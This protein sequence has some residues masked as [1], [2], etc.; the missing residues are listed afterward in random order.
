MLISQIQKETDEHLSESTI[1]E[2][3]EKILLGVSF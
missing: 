2:S 3:T 1:A